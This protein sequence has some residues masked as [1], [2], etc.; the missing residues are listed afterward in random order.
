MSFHN[1]FS[2]RFPECVSFIFIF[3]LTV[4]PT[5]PFFVFLVLY[6]GINVLPSMIWQFP[7][8]RPHTSPSLT[9]LFW[10]SFL[11]LILPYALHGLAFLLQAWSY[12]LYDLR[13]RIPAQNAALA[14]VLECILLYVPYLK[15]FYVCLKWR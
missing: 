13:D 5:K 1:L 11:I 2:F 8:H 10:S 7:A 3:L 15:R 4:S 14:F 12:C 6:A 9:C